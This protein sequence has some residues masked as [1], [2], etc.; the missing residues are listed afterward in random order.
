MIDLDNPPV[1]AGGALITLTAR[2]FQY[3]M[4]YCGFERGAANVNQEVYFIHSAPTQDIGGR[5]IH[6]NWHITAMTTYRGGGRLH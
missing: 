2:A 5:N 1:P 4:Q 6:P 3:W